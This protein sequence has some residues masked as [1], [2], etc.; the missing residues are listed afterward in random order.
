[1]VIIWTRA[2]SLPYLALAGVVTRR[3]PRAIFAE[4]FPKLVAAYGRRTLSQR[5]A[6][7]VIAFALGGSAERLQK[8]GRGINEFV[9][10][11]NQ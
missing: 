9:V 10:R 3:C 8:M 5:A 7:E 4:R 2:R 6:L 11:M 1:V